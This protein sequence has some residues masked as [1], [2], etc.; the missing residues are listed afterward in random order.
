MAKSNRPAS[1]ILEPERGCVLSERFVLER[2]RFRY[3]CKSVSIDAVTPSMTSMPR[4]GRPSAPTARSC[5]VPLLHARNI[6]RQPAKVSSE[7]INVIIPRVLPHVGK[8][9]YYIK[10]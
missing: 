2:L 7:N 5:K 9:F 4:R 3:C 1:A 8:Q 10:L 6:R